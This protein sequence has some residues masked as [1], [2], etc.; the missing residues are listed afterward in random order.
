MS[1]PAPEP[2]KPEITLEDIKHQVV[3]V[4]DLAVSDAKAQFK[5]T[6]QDDMVRTVMV[7]ALGVAVIASVAYLLG[8]RAGRALPPP[9]PC[10][11]GCTPL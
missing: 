2:S 10:P 11:P 8:N 5:A 9:P 7:V 3:G 4:R 6:V 1:K